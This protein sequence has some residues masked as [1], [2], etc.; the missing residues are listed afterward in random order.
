MSAWPR[1]LVNQTVHPSAKSLWD[2][3]S[4]GRSRLTG[5]SMGWRPSTPPPPFYRTDTSFLAKISTWYL[6]RMDSELE[7]WV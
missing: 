1:S 5:G 6:K 2:R 3:R 7:V 4:K